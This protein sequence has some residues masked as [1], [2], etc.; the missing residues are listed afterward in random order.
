[1][2][3]MLPRKAMLGW[4][5][6]LVLA[7]LALPAAAANI[8]KYIDKDGRT[9]FNSFIPAEYV[10]NGYT[11][12]NE[13]GQVVQ[14]VPRAAT[15]EELNAQQ[16]AKAAEDAALAARLA[17]EEAD[18]LLIRL[19]RTPE[20]IERKR[21]NNVK[22]LQTQQDLVSLN[23]T[24]TEAEIKAAQ[25][26]IDNTNKLGRPVTD[27]MKKRLDEANA[28]KA[29][30]QAQFDIGRRT[31]LDLMNS[32]NELFQARSSLTNGSF[33]VTQAEYRLLAAMGGLLKILGIEQK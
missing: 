14:V 13:Q 16:A 23:L 33:A 22:Q 8:Y 19:Y 29:T 24:K 7:T 28:D 30:Y 21:D 27:D 32:E 3:V 17:Q 5:A 4:L 2:N 25:T 26:A 6:G 10:K 20:D 12:L 31:M 1:M 15:A 9:V 11:I 18:K